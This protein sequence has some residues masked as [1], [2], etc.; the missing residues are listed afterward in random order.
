M[1]LKVLK[2]PEIEQKVGVFASPDCARCRRF[3]PFLVLNCLG[4]V[5]DATSDE[6]W[7]RHGS[8]LA[9]IARATKR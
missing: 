6:P 8:D 3:L 7:G 4:Q 2:V 5:L 1:N 9:D